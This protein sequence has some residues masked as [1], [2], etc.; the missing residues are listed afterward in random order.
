MKTYFTTLA[1]ICFFCC[2]F[3]IGAT[4][5]T[6]DWITSHLLLTIFIAVATGLVVAEIES[7]N[8]EKD[9]I[10]KWEIARGELVYKPDQGVVKMS[11]REKEL[12]D[13]KRRLNLK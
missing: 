11:K 10:R 7:T 3:V 13:L 9:D 6:W 4:P 5:Q 12:E 8:R 2:L 1:L